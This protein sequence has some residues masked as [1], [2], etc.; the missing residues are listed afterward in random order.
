MDNSTPS[1]SPPNPPAPDPL[2]TAQAN[3][4]AAQQAFVAAQQQRSSEQNDSV[5]GGPASTTTINVVLDPDL[6]ALFND[7]SVVANNAYK[8]VIAALQAVRLAQQ[9]AGSLAAILTKLG[10]SPAGQSEPSVQVPSAPQPVAPITN[11]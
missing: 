5:L 11:T 6:S 8:A 1:S 9:T 4:I 3:L 2:D 10:A 7:P